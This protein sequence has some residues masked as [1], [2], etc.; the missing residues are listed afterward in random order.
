MIIS[1]IFPPP[2][3]VIDA[4]NAPTTRVYSRIE[5]YEQ[6]GKTR[7]ADDQIDRLVDG[8]VSVDYTRDE[9]R[10]VELELNNQDG[11]LVTSPGH[12]WYD[13]VIKF[14]KRI[15]VR[16]GATAAVF[17]TNLCPTPSFENNLLGAWSP[18][19]PSAPTIAAS[20]DFAVQGT[21]SLKFTSTG[22]NSLAGAVFTVTLTVGQVYTLSTYAYVPVG[23]RDLQVMV[24]SIGFGTSTNG[25][26]DQWVRISMTFTATSASTTLGI[27]QDSTV[28]GQ[29]G[30]IDGVLLEQSSTLG[31]YFDGSFPT[32]TTPFVY[33]WNGT[34]E[35]SSS[36]QAAPAVDPFD[37]WE[38][39]V[40]EFMIDS[41]VEDRF[42]RHIH[43]T[44]RDY[45]KRALN[46]KFVVTTQFDPPYTLELLIGDLAANAGISKMILPNTGKTVHSTFTYERG[47]S[48]WEAMKEI[49]NAYN[50]DVFFGREGNLRMEIFPDPATQPPAYIFQT[51]EEGNL[52]EFTKTTDDSELYNH[53]LVAGHNDT[54]E[55]FAEAKNTTIDSPTSIAEIGDRLYEYDSDLLLIRRNWAINPSGEYTTDGVRQ[56]NGGGATTLSTQTDHAPGSQGTK[57]VRSTWT[58][59][60]SSPAGGI[61]VSTS[62]T[63]TLRNNSVPPGTV[64]STRI[65]IKTNKSNS[66]S[67]HIDWRDGKDNI[68]GS[69]VQTVAFG[70]SANTWY[71]IAMVSATAPAR[72]D[73]S[74]VSIR[75]DSA[76]GT[77][78]N[79]GDWF[80]IDDVIIERADTPGDYFDGDYYGCDWAGTVGDSRSVSNQQAQMLADT[81]LSVHQLEQFSLDLT[82]LNVFYLDVGKTVQFIDPNPASGDPDMFL[83][84]SL[85]IP[86]GLGL[87]TATAGRVTNVGTGGK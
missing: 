25:I 19:G 66:V 71:A 10:T 37:A 77:I 65:W 33:A 68:I 22:A 82:A 43:I 27:H 87:M 47:V 69:D 17:R 73:H 9:R 26:R 4:I 41:I 39:Q 18:Q 6:D 72:C 58:T 74:V 48:R 21:H 45:T 79:V 15:R 34:V 3:V 35:N 7:W 29:I 64:I 76:S 59:A 38:C 81:F 62:Q 5:I 57:C 12:L 28:A 13:K 80:Q 14:F 75:V 86:V 8:S 56:F 63:S 44:G 50:Y 55:A 70:I 31:S 67:M 2:Q 85:T 20:T 84:Q 36:T 46:S 51:G 42:P 83:L 49:A 53:V 60:G 24:D 30:Y 61:G 40:G 1:R 32:A 23:N 16:V 54:G 11:V 78:M 52:S